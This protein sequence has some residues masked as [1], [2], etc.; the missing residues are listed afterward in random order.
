MIKLYHNP[1]W[2]KSRK[3]VEILN[4]L[5][6]NYKL[7][8]YVKTG[9]TIK[10]LEGLCE[11]LNLKAIEFIRY[12][13]KL[14]KENPDFK[15]I[16]ENPKLLDLISKYPKIIQRPI[17]VKDSKAIIARPPELINDFLL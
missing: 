13:D 9:F 7:I 15:K 8:E 1:Q 16:S 11:K 14:F 5:K 4:D 17:V 2:S 12:N 10:E 6:I 3:S